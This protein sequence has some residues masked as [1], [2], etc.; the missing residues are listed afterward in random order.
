MKCDIQW[1]ANYRVE[2]CYREFFL[3]LR[4]AS[5]SL[6]F[7][8]MNFGNPMGFRFS[9]LRSSLRMAGMLS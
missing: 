7:F 6:M 2:K 4:A 3:R 5:S 8:Q 9:F 1:H